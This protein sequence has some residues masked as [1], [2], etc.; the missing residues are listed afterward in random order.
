[1]PSSWLPGYAV[2]IPFHRRLWERPHPYARKRPPIA[3]SPL[4]NNYSVIT[5]NP[6]TCRRLLCSRMQTALSCHAS[7]VT[8][9]VCWCLLFGRR[10]KL[11]QKSSTVKVITSY[12][13]HGGGGHI[14]EETKKKVRSHNLDSSH[15]LSLHFCKLDRLL[16]AALLLEVSKLCTVLLIV[17][18][19]YI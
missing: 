8:F 12:N 9:L 4:N 2:Q 15:L 18:E 16:Q 1:M 19:M 7:V 10:K 6:R 13:K 3:S 11:S 5:D 14:K 17:V